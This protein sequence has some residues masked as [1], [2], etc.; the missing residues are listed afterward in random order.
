[1]RRLSG[2]NQRGRTQVKIGLV[3]YIVAQFRCHLRADYTLIVHLKAQEQRALAQ[4]EANLAGR[5]A[6]PRS[7]NESAT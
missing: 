4:N 5:E 1:M 3:T 2:N 6:G 7:D